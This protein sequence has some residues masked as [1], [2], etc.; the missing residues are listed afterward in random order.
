[1]VEN[2][3]P[4]GTVLCL[5]CKS[6]VAYVRGQK[7]SFFNHLKAN[8]NVFFNQNYIMAINCFDG[9]IRNKVEQYFDKTNEELRESQALTDT[10][11]QFFQDE[12]ECN[13]NYS[14]SPIYDVRE[15]QFD[16]DECNNSYSNKAF[17][18]KLSLIHI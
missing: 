13:T 15:E 17:L 3:L 5:L 10:S 14:Q 7:S 6:V 9:E 4:P 8:H 12:A 11:E 16:C 1:M 18:K 2:I